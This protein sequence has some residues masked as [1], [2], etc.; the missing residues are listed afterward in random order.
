MTRSP[1]HGGPAGPRVLVTGAS[2]S[3]GT[4]VCAGL[5]QLGWTVRQL[6]LVAPGQPPPAPH[7]VV[8]GDIADADLLAT[9][10]AGCDAVVHL[11]AIAGEAG[12]EQIAASHVV[13]A[14]LVLQ[15]A[16]EAGVER[17]VFA[18]SNHAVG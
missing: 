15:A 12:I 5:P 4:A 11:A 9:A 3:V 2:G 13:G 10:M 6:D 7:E 14:A 8:V 16:H 17:F 18:S 1:D